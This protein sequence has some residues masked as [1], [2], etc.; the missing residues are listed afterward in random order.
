MMALSNAEKQKRWRDKRNR[1]AKQASS[2]EGLIAALA[3]A[4]KGKTDQEIQDIANE[5][6]ERLW[7]PRHKRSRKE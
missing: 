6:W 3:R 5:V 7:A 2:V 1:L 4:V